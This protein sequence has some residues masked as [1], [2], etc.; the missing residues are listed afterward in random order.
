MSVTGRLTPQHRPAAGVSDAPRHHVGRTRAA[1]GEEHVVDPGALGRVADLDRGEHLGVALATGER[2]PVRADEGERDRPLG[3]RVEREHELLHG[4]HRGA[5]RQPDL[6]PVVA[7]LDVV[8]E[9]GVDQR[10]VVGVGG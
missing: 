2:R 4:Q 3:R 1:A 6:D 8:E 7:Q 9:G 5:P 10:A